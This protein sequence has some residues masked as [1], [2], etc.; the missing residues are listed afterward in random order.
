MMSSPATTSFLSDEKSASASKHCAGRRLAKRSISL[1]RRSR[2]RSG[3]TEKSSVVFR[4]AHGAQ[5]H[6]VDLLR[7]G[8]RRVVGQRRAVRVIGAP[9]TRSSLTSK[10]MP[11]R[12][13][14][15]DDLAH[16]GHDLGAD[17]V[18]GQDKQGAVGH[19]QHAMPSA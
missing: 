3:F 8:H 6:R 16:L 19:A 5:Q 18:A 2:P 7:L 13:E 14:P 9:P 4:P 17:A 15:V 10:A 12:A 1:R 11:A